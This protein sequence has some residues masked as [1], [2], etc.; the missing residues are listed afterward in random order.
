MYISD[1]I[2]KS[3]VVIKV[4]GEMLAKVFTLI[5]SVAPVARR[6]ASKLARAANPSFPR[7]SPFPLILLF[8][9][10]AI[11]ANVPIDLFASL[12]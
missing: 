1:K 6:V 12:I 8:L 5:K 10:S 11:Q 4:N 3:G 7:R 2:E 9:L